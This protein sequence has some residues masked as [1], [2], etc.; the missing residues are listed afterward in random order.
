M[1]RMEPAYNRA[2]V[3]KTVLYWK[4]CTVRHSLTRVIFLEI[5]FPCKETV[6]WDFSELFAFHRTPLGPYVRGHNDFNFLNFLV[7]IWVF[8]WLCDEDSCANWKKA[9]FVKRFCVYW[10]WRR[11]YMSGLFNEIPLCEGNLLLMI[12][13]VVWS[14]TARVNFNFSY[15]ELTLLYTELLIY[16]TY[17]T[18]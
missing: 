5:P 12:I 11:A 4:I 2:S 6:S 14:E 13:H 7:D 1:D 18:V 16:W 8:G 15:P 3:C 17:Y 9:A 10:K